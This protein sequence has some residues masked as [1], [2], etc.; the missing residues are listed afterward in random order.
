MTSGVAI[1]IVAEGTGGEPKTNRN[2]GVL[3]GIGNL[4][5]NAIDFAA[6]EVRIVARWT[7]A[8]VAIVCGRRWPGLRA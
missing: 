1:R 3:Y 4:V 8:I 2:P 7:E 6:G 5:E